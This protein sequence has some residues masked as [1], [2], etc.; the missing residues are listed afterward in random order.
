MQA[1]P[2]LAQS[3]ERKTRHRQ[4]LDSGSVFGG[5]TIPPVELPEA[6]RSMSRAPLTPHKGLRQPRGR[7]GHATALCVLDLPT[8]VIWSHSRVGGIIGD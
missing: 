7:P 6:E 2:A 8:S 3:E 4:G 5:N 1:P